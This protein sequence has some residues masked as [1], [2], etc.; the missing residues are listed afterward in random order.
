MGTLCVDLHFVGSFAVQALIDHQTVYASTLG[1]YG[2]GVFS[3]SDILMSC[4]GNRLNVAAVRAL[5][6]ASDR[7]GRFGY[8]FVIV[9]GRCNLCDFYV[10]A[11]R[12]GICNASCC[13]AGCVY[14]SGFLIIV[15]T[16]CGR[17]HISLGCVAP[18]ALII[19]VT[20]LGAGCIQ[21]SGFHET[22]LG[23]IFRSNIL[24]DMLVTITTIVGGITVLRTGR[25]YRRTLLC[26]MLMTALVYCESRKTGSDNHDDRQHHCHELC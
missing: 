2:F 9:A 1:Q 21:T 3:V 26:C 14:T 25:S 11:S 24:Q 8:R 6:G 19:H 7:A 16:L 20:V 5:L 18:L 15:T 12:A 4:S 13:G 10:T 23:V 22:V 17:Q